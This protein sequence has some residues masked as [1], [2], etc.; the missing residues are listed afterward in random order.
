MEKRK[1]FLTTACPLKYGVRSTTLQQEQLLKSWYRKTLLYF[2][3]APF[4]NFLKVLVMKKT[5]LGKSEVN[6]EKIKVNIDLKFEVYKFLN[7]IVDFW[8]R[9][10]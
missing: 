7:L 1:M 4:Q 8:T 3:I 9:V 2:L 6:L 10:G 5:I